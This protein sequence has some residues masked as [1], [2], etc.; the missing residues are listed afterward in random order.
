MS[1]VRIL[2]WRP[3]RKSNLL[4]FA[5]IELQSGMV[6]TDV[7]ILTSE[8]GPWASPPAKPMIS[9]DRTV[10]KTTPGK[11]DIYPSTKS[12][13]ARFVRW[14]D[15]VIEAMRLAHPEALR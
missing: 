15:A 5:K 12:H 1:G 8:R 10:R 6:I 7:A 4:G 3:L 11:S 14:S 2:D 13:P 9:G